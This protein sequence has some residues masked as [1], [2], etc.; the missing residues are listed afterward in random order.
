MIDHYEDPQNVGSFD[1]KSADVGTGVCMCV[2]ES[3]KEI[4]T[5]R[6]GVKAWVCFCVIVFVFAR[7]CAFVCS[8]LYCVRVY[9]CER[10]Y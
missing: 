9:V 10:H 3:L 1:K 2:R 8:M 5:V 7:V 6:E 4:E